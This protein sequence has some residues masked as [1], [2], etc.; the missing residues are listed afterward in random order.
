MRHGLG[1][2]PGGG[3]GQP[4]GQSTVDRDATDCHPTRS[5][6]PPCGTTAVV[7]GHA[8]GTDCRPC[9]LMEVG[10]LHTR[11][12]SHDRPRSRLRRT[13][14]SNN[15]GA[16][17]LDILTGKAKRASVQARRGASAISPAGQAR[18]SRVHGCATD[19]CTLLREPPPD[20]HARWRHRY[21]DARAQRCPHGALFALAGGWNSQPAHAE[22]RYLEV[23]FEH[24][25]TRVM[26]HA[27]LFLSAPAERQPPA[28]Q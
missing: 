2:H 4:K 25:K 8:R 20:R 26:R 18:P 9:A 17:R 27:M 24:R 14:W 16:A 21:P 12:R 23:S 28:T 6:G 13:P 3:R 10:G 22:S 5:R 1:E 7:Q 15:T 11:N 19:E